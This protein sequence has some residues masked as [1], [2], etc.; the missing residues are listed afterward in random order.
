MI[1]TIAWGL[2]MGTTLAGC[3]NKGVELN[4]DKAVKFDPAKDGP[5]KQSGP[6]E[7]GDKGPKGAGGKGGAGTPP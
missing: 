7:G 2:L 6:P 5:G 4:V 3:S 1:R